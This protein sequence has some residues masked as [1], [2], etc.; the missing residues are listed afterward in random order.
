[1][2]RVWHGQPCRSAE[3]G[4]RPAGRRAIIKGTFVMSA[5]R[6]TRGRLNMQPPG[7]NIYAPLSCAE[8]A[9]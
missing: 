7:L 5:S 2:I 4:D 1:M 8:N 9:R 3:P 6:Q